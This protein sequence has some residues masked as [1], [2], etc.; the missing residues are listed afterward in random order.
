MASDSSTPAQKTIFK[1]IS[2]ESAEDLDLDIKVGSSKFSVRGLVENF[3]KAGLGQAQPFVWSHA[4]GDADFPSLHAQMTS[5]VSTAKEILSLYTE[6][7]DAG[8]EVKDFLQKKEVVELMEASS[9]EVEDQ[10]KGIL[11]N[12]EPKKFL[13]EF[14]GKEEHVRQR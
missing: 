13:S 3:D 4:F 2:L 9:A 1:K 8:M 14:L 10:K 6:S 5:Y 12:D 7:E 11:G